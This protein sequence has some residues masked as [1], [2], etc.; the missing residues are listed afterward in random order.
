MIDLEKRA[1]ERTVLSFDEVRELYSHIS[2]FG[3]LRG[4]REM[5][6]LCESHERLRYEL[7]R[8]N[9]ILSLAQGDEEL[10]NKLT[11]LARTRLLKLV[12]GQER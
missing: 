4:E 1:V 8:A 6:S 5:A 10:W 2:P 11:D 3:S 9:A 7:Q 12:E